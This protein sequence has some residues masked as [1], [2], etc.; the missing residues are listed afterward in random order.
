MIYTLIIKRQ[1]KKKLESLSRPERTRITEK[2]IML[3]NNPDDSK[4]DI[5]ALQGDPYYRLR[6]GKWR[7]IFD[8]REV[9]RISAIE[10]IK[11]R[12]DAY[13]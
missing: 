1:A 7:V 4:L 11:P 2:I 3:A 5:K 10:H 13:K 6:I 12:G 9:V 8:R